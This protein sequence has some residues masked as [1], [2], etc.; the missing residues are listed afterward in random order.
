M[1][2]VNFIKSH[3]LSE[4]NMEKVNIFYIIVIQYQMKRRIKCK[5]KQQ[6]KPLNQSEKS[7]NKWKKRIKNE[8]DASFVASQFV[9]MIIKR[10]W[11]FQ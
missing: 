11:N 9:E 10:N 2:V 8:E 7:K 4:A 6:R 3:H 1:T 5:K